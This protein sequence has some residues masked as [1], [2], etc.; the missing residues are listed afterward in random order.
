MSYQTGNPS[1]D[2]QATASGMF[3]NAHNF[4]ITDSVFNAAG[5]D[6]VT[7]YYLSTEE[8]SKLKEWLAAPDC[9]TNYTAALNKRVGGTGQWIFE[10][11]TY[12]E[13]KKGGSILWIHGKGNVY[14]IS[15]DQI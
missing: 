8:E 15:T 1:Y 10:D 13:W 11:P 2:M 4:T 5:R 12:L 6:V 3:N 14:L 7:Q 9:S